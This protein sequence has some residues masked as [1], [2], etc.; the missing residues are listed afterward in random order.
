MTKKEEKHSEEKEQARSDVA[1]ETVSQKT[2]TKVASLFK[3][4]CMC[5]RGVY[6]GDG[7]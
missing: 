5:D 2:G 7:I 3:L 4:Y 1:G 6:G